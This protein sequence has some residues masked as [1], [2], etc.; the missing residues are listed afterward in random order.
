MQLHTFIFYEMIPILLTVNGGNML[1]P[2]VGSYGWFKGDWVKIHVVYPSFDTLFYGDTSSVNAMTEQLCIW[3][4]SDQLLNL[5]GWAEAV[6]I[7]L[8]KKKL[9]T[10]ALCVDSWFFFFMISK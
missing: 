9:K 1:A 4:N 5:N 2:N 3:I 10:G 6:L 7:T 8:I